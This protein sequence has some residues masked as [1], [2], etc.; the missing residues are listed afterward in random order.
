[1]QKLRLLDENS[2]VSWKARG[3]RNWTI[4]ERTS[5]AR[6]V[7]NL[8]LR[9][10]VAYFTCDNRREFTVFKSLKE[11]RDNVWMARVCGKNVNHI[12]LFPP[13]A[14]CPY[15]VCFIFYAREA[16]KMY[17]KKANLREV[18]KK[19]ESEN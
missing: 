4:R 2:A 9:K 13:D 11:N 5:G 18:D 15:I 16:S 7:M 17:A 6:V 8:P 10:K 1:M 14:S 19:H 3:I 12:Q